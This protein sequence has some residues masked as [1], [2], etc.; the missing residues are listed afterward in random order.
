MFL[1]VQSNTIED[2]NDR[3]HR[4]T[5]GRNKIS[6]NVKESLKEKRYLLDENNTTGKVL[7]N[8]IKKLEKIKNNELKG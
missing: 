5:F 6:S 8:P 4:L 7:M 3:V 1:T 2:A